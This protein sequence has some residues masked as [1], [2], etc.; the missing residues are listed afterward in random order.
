[1]SQ[2]GVVNFAKQKYSVE[3]WDVP[4]P[5]VGEEDVL[6]EVGSVGVCGSDLHQWAGDH[7]WA[8][9]YPVVLGHEFSGVIREVGS[10]VNGWHEGD[11][12]VSE[13]AAVIDPA[14]PMSSRRGLYNLA[15]DP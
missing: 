15:P 14:N 2:A 3:L 11:R 9:N 10:R 13:T 6:L 5:Q 4:G 12:V 1:M 7:G 8:V